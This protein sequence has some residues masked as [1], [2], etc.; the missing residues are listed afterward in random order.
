MYGSLHFRPFISDLDCHP[1]TSL[2]C[3]K[4]SDCWCAI[5]LLVVHKMMKKPG[6]KCITGG[7]KIKIEPGNKDFRDPSMILK[8]RWSLEVVLQ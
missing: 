6:N 3:T 4:F 8:L 5:F 2:C 1:L 7:K